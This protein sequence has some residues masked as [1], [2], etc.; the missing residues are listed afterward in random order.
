M[1]A[2]PCAVDGCERDYYARGFCT[3]HYTRWHRHGSTDKPERPTPAKH[4]PANPWAG[5]ET[6]PSC[7]SSDWTLPFDA[8][9]LP[10]IWNCCLCGTTFT[11]SPV[12][13]RT[14]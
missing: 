2:R 7:G 1:T 13:A 6:C 12:E 10:H 8:A 3:L 9:D 14:A 11:L 5:R 4:A